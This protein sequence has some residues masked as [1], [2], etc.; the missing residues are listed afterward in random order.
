LFDHAAELANVVLVEGIVE[1]SVTGKEDVAH[2]G[3]LSPAA[4]SIKP[5][6]R[7]HRSSTATFAEARTAAYLR[8]ESSARP[9]NSHS[10]DIS[11]SRVLCVRPDLHRGQLPPRDV[12]GHEH[13]CA[14]PHHPLGDLWWSSGASRRE[15]RSWLGRSRLTVQRQYAERL[16]D[17]VRWCG[18][19]PVALLGF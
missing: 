11:F 9:P 3:S 7:H 14:W 1:R 12:G 17:V 6:V 18:L 15:R 2:A 16:S 13:S 5:C 10:R 4:T 8:A 19:P